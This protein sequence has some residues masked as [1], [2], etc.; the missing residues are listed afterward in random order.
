ME[1]N[2]VSLLREDIKLEVLNNDLI[3]NNIITIPFYVVDS[4]RGLMELTVIEEYRIFLEYRKV[5][6]Q[7]L[8]I[9]KSFDSVYKVTE[10][11]NLISISM[12]IEEELRV[13]SPPHL[14]V[15]IKE[16]AKK[17]EERIS[18]N[19]YISVIKK[20]ITLSQLRGHEEIEE[21]SVTFDNTK[22]NVVLLGNTEEVTE[23]T[24]IST[25]SE[26]FKNVFEDLLNES[27]TTH[28]YK[29][30]VLGV[31]FIHQKIEGTDTDYFVELLVQNDTL[32]LKD[33]PYQLDSEG[34]KEFIENE[35]FKMVNKISIRAYESIIKEFKRVLCS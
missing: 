4:S 9:L 19:K 14:E 35:M 12:E 28:F 17:F 18:E 34:N 25:M 23:I 13:V 8:L 24:D 29:N 20:P 32:T 7:D 11:G 16:F 1:N 26:E 2:W 27:E 10:S 31:R 30:T 5:F 15:T 6:E 22:N 33:Y 21:T 3:D